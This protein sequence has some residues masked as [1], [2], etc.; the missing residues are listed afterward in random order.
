M[1]FKQTG[2][3]ALAVLSNLANNTIKVTDPNNKLLCTIKSNSSAC[4]FHDSVKRVYFFCAN[5]SSIKFKLF[6]PEQMQQGDVTK[7]QFLY[8]EDQEEEGIFT[9][10]PLTPLREEPDK[11]LSLFWISDCFVALNEFQ[12]HIR[13]AVVKTQALCGIGFKKQVAWEVFYQEF[14]KE[15]KV[16]HRSVQYLDKG[17]VKSLKLPNQTGFLLSVV[18]ENEDLEEVQR[19]S[20]KIRF[21]SP[22]SSYEIM[23]NSVQKNLVP[24]SAKI[25]FN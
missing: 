9:L 7:P 17:K 22:R 19:M 18:I 4:I 24:L 21:D 1:K 12:D 13:I 5:N 23:L 3:L 10:K 25:F 15:L 11:L 2:P 16:N 8:L 6:K 14:P 20:A